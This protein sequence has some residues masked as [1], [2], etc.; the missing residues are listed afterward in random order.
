MG[1]LNRHGSRL[2]ARERGRIRRRL[3]EIGEQREERLRDLGGLALDMRRREQID[4][5]LLWKPAAEI[6]AL[7][8][9]AQLVRKGL[10]EGLSLAQLEEIAKR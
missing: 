1:L 5:G 7:D 10:D 6:A 2:T 3:R 4:R 9:E 8:D